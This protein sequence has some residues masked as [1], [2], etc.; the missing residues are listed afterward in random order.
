MA[1]GRC[2]LRLQFSNIFRS[3]LVMWK[4]S[5]FGIWCHV[6]LV[7]ADVWEECIASIIRVRR[8]RE[9]VTALAA[10][11][12]R[13]SLRR[14]TT[15]YISLPTRA[16]RRHI[17][18]DG[19][20]HSHRRENLK[21]SIFVICFLR[22]MFWRRGCVVFEVY[23]LHAVA[24]CGFVD[25]GNLISRGSSRPAKCRPIILMGSMDFCGF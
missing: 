13:S 15:S 14:N 22:S 4:I 2:P 11:S 17:S 9:P 6:T 20:L 12:N 8:I 24:L 7:R 3:L 5:S 25:G 19:I 18:E 10:T 16:T 23:V 21:F 1:M